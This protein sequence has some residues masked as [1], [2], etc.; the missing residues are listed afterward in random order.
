MASYT[1]PNADQMVAWTGLNRL[2]R[3]DT[4]SEF[5]EWLETLLPDAEAEVACSLTEELFDGSTWTARKV[6][7]IQRWVAYYV[8]AIALCSPELQ[9]ATGTH[10]PLVIQDAEQISEVRARLRRD[11]LALKALILVGIDLQPGTDAPFAMPSVGASTYDLD[12]SDRD[13][14]EKN[15]LQDER[16]GVPADD[17]DG[18][19]A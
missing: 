14:V 1:A 18:V 15:E 8:A 2:I 5:N 3:I 12:S 19:F 4:A 6:L 7:L 11:G 13:V 10:K 17:T 16:D 9:R